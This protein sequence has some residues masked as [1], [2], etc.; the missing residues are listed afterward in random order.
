MGGVAGLTDL[1]LEDPRV[2]GSG[3]H[4]DFLKLAILIYEPQADGSLE[5][6]AVENLVFA[7]A[8]KEVGTTRPLVPPVLLTPRSTI[9]RHRST[10][11]TC[12]SRTGTVVHRP[13]ANSIPM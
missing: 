1:S 2:N 13:T 9:Q 7:G 8:W 3:I 11:R 5:L 6:V 10:R 4:T 12:S